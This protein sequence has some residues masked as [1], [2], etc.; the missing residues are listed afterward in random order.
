MQVANF[1]YE[2]QLNIVKHYNYLMREREFIK[3]EEFIYKFGKTKQ[4]FN[5]RMNQYPKDSE[6]N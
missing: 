2:E 1:K 5:K 4:E 3:T 6:I